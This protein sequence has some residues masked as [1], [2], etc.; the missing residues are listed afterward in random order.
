LQK[1]AILFRRE[2]KG[3]ALQ[4]AEKLAIGDV[5]ATL[6]RHQ[7]NALNAHMAG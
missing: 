4:A 3:G 6:R 1:L 7:P 5:A 2:W